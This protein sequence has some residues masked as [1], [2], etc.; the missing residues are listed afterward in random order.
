VEIADYISIA[1]AVFIVVIIISVIRSEIH[2]RRYHRHFMESLR[3]SQMKA[4]RSATDNWT[5]SACKQ[6]KT[7]DLI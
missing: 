2:E 6:R 3:R 5:W 1:S 7:F 4:E